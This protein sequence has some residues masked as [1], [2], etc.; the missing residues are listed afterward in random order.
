MVNFQNKQQVH[1]T[2]I[3]TYKLSETPLAK[4]WKSYIEN[5][6][7]HHVELGSTKDKL[8]AHPSAILVLTISFFFS[9]AH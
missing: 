4:L 1:F 8:E 6:L 5:Q 2:L 9:N 7:L 3:F